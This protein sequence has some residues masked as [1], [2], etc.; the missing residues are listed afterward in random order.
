MK[1]AFANYSDKVSLTCKKWWNPV[2]PRMAK[3]FRIK[4]LDSN[5][6]IIDQTDGEKDNNGRFTNRDD[7]NGKLTQDQLDKNEPKTIALDA[8]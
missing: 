4:T 3:G 1:Y 2:Y 8:T 5:G 6:N 7:I